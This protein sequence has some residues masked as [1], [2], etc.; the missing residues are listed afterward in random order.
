MSQ[1]DRRYR[2]LVTMETTKRS[3]AMPLSLRTAERNDMNQ[4]AKP[5]S[6]SSV[7]S[8]YMR[9]ANSGLNEDRDRQEGYCLG[10]IQK[11]WKKP[12][13]GYLT[14]TSLLI[15]SIYMDFFFLKFTVFKYILWYKISSKL[16]WVLNKKF[17]K[18]NSI[19]TLVL[20]S[21]TATFINKAI[22]PS[23]INS[24]TFQVI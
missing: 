9:K 3:E 18:Y 6:Q 7:W 22:H 24:L 21:K 13:P 19:S 11:I 2:V 5:C 16:M 23:S 10:S 8:S 1:T 4:N 12:K 14:V 15:S 20:K 17:N